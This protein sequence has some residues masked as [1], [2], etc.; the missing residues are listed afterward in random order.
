[1]RVYNIEFM[2][3][4]LKYKYIYNISNFI[5]FINIYGQKLCLQREYTEGTKSWDQGVFIKGGGVWTL[6]CP[7]TDIPS[8]FKLS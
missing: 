8:F 4:F 7:R 1:M 6:Y 3:T 5:T 2:P